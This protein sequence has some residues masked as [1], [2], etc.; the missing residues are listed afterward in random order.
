[1]SESLEQGAC[2][3]PVINRELNMLSHLID[4]I[5]DEVEESAVIPTFLEER[6]SAVLATDCSDAVKQG[7]ELEEG[8][9]PLE[10]QLAEALQV[11]RQRLN[12]VPRRLRRLRDRTHSVMSRLEVA[13]DNRPAATS[14]GKSEGS[15]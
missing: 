10:P 7:E 13:P 14:I 4:A 3:E 2:R 12:G 11:M 6:L 5:N 15:H 9:A 1:M 8:E